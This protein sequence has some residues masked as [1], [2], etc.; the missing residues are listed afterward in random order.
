MTALQLGTLPCDCH[1]ERHDLKLIAVTGGPG[2]GKT[3]VLELASRAFCSH[4]AIFPEAASIVFSGG[5]PRHQNAAG[6]RAAQRAIFHIQCEV[7]QLVRE[8]NEVAVGLCDRGT[9]DGLAYWPDSPERYWAELETT[10]EREYARYAAVVHLE[11]PDAEEGYNHQNRLRVESPAEAKAL[12]D[13]IKRAWSGHPRRY[14]VP[15][16]KDFVAKAHQALALLR[17]E[18]PSCC[19]PHDISRD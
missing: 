7:E 11:T 13:A 10:P 12:D 9:V 3:A 14:V 2:A 1:L 17:D 5:F 16:S 6:R 15:S 4:V 18:L 8:E 19:R